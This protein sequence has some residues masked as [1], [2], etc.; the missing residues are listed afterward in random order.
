MTTWTPEAQA[1]TN[2]SVRQSGSIRRITQDGRRRVTERGNV[3]IIE[4]FAFTWTIA[5]KSPDP[6][7]PT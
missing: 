4:R 3:R 6:W 2:W 7:Q 1:N 5:V